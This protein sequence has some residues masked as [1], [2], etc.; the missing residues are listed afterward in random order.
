MKE[1]TT[2]CPSPPRAG[3]QRG[4]IGVIGKEKLPEGSVNSGTLQ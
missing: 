4:E 3:Q 1:A 2:L